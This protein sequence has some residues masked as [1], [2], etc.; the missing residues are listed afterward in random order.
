MTYA[1]QVKAEVAARYGVP[2][3][4]EVQFIPRGV[5]TI[6]PLASVSYRQATKWRFDAIN[7]GRQLRAAE[8]PQPAPKLK[9]RGKRKLSEVNSQKLAAEIAKCE[10]ALCGVVGPAARTALTMRCDGKSYRQ[11]AQ[12]TRMQ[13][14]YVHGLLK[15]ALD[16]QTS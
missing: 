4:C 3:L 6:D 5:Q 13:V 7:R 16:I 2:V 14:S 1:D 15:R 10:A 9:Q 12:A 11:I 8:Q